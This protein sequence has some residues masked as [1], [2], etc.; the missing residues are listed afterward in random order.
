MAI[1]LT[2]KFDWFALLTNSLVLPLHMHFQIYVHECAC[3]CACVQ[4]ACTLFD[5]SWSRGAWNFVPPLHYGSFARHLLA[6]WLHEHVQAFLVF[7]A[8]NGS[9]TYSP[10][11]KYR[12]ITGLWPASTAE[13]TMCSARMCRGWVRKCMDVCVSVWTCVWVYGF[14]CACGWVSNWAGFL[15]TFNLLT[16]M[17]CLRTVGRHIGV[18]VAH[19]VHNIWVYEGNMRYLSMRNI[20]LRCPFSAAKCMAVLRLRLWPWTVKHARVNVSTTVLAFC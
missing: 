4:Y 7:V 19:Y 14:V 3:V 12:A 11:G 17:A 6:A 5:W 13:K 18:W 10:R 1:S 9:K 8:I 15:R 16:A 2:L 20:M